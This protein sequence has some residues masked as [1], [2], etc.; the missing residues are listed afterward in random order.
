MTGGNLEPSSVDSFLSR[1]E[2]TLI[3]VPKDFGLQQADFDFPAGGSGFVPE[4]V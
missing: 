3:L 1:S 2:E 4:S